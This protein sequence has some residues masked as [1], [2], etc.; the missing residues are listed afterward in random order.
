MFI[1]LLQG[2]SKPQIQLVS[3]VDTVQVNVSR[4]TQ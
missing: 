3:F 4:L 1:I 2:E